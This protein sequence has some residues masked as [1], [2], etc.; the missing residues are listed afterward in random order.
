MCNCGFDIRHRVFGQLLQFCCAPAAANFFIKSSAWSTS[1]HVRASSCAF[2]SAGSKVSLCLR[3]NCA[4]V[5]TFASFCTCASIAVAALA[6]A[7]EAAVTPAAGRGERRLQFCFIL[8]VS[9]VF[10]SLDRRGLCLEFIF[11]F[12]RQDRVS[13]ST[14]GDRPAATAFWIASSS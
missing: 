9:G 3:L 14:V 4:G 10:Q 1:A 12:G 2:E 6:A 5:H 7:L 13:I 11:S 8:R